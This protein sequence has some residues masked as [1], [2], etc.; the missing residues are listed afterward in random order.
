[1]KL[2][3]KTE[4]NIKKQVIFTDGLI[5]GGKTLISNLVSG[6]KN[7]EQW[8]L[9]ANFERICQYNALNKIDLDTSADFI[10]KIYNEKYYDQFI[11]R[12]ANFRKFDISSVLNHSR[13]KKF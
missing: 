1:M 7:V 4:L 6:L 2:F 9:E 11:L 12:H 5:G 13:K 10:K 8:V 3:F